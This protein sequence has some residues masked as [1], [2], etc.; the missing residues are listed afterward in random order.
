MVLGAGDVEDS[1]MEV[2]RTGGGGLLYHARKPFQIVSNVAQFDVGAR[3]DEQVPRWS[4]YIPDVNLRLAQIGPEIQVS[5]PRAWADF[6]Y[7]HGILAY[8][9]TRG[10][11][12][13]LLRE[14]RELTL[15]VDVLDPITL[16]FRRSNRSYL[17]ERIIFDPL[18]Q[19]TLELRLDFQI[20]S[21]R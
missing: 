3:I 17:N 16:E 1:A 12:G 11:P 15:R 9:Y 6:D 8:E 19:K 10:Y 20:P 13:S 5:T 21:L 14:N 2:Q 7:G 4:G 18:D